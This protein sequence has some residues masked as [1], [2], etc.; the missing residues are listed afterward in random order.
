MFKKILIVGAVGL[1]AAAV[2]TQTKVGHFLSHKWNQ[3]EKH[4]ESK[5]PPEE[6]IE[7]IKGEVASLNKDIDKAKGEL[8]S[9]NVEVRHLNSFVNDLRVRTE[10][11]REAV[12][13]R[14]KSLKDAGDSKLVKWDGRSIDFNRA[15]ESLAKEVANHK[16]L[17][18]EYKANETMLA[19][20]EQTRTMAE[21]HLQALISQKAEM[22]TA[23]VELEALIKQVKVEQVQSKYQ[24]DGTRMAQVKED[25]AKL[26]KRIEV[27]REKLNLSRKFDVNSVD[28]RSVDEILAELDTKSEKSTDLVNK[29]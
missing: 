19:V 16:S 22:E 20:R 18:K 6:E 12:E 26:R 2:L 11:S 23:V 24:D 4:F 25:L 29:K 1:L 15:K 7:R 10:K 3:A 5:I 9:E 13:A 28:N 21:Q 14:G 17:E 27:Q 8:A